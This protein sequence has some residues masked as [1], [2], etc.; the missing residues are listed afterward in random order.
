MVA[1]YKSKY[2]TE[3]LTISFIVLS[4]IFI[5]LSGAT[6]SSLILSLSLFI[7]M[8]PKV[9]N[10][11]SRLLDSLAMVSWPKLHHKKII[12]AKN[13]GILLIQIKNY[14]NLMKKYFKSVEFQY[15]NSNKIFK[16]YKSFY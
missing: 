2:I 1:S 13:L 5:I 14:L 11:Q 4:I 10:A 9:Y 6:A 15:P 12:W 16:K 7:R 8:T 3:L